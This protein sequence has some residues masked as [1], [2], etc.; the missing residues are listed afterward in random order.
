MAD[1]LKCKHCYEFVSGSNIP[2]TES[3]SIFLFDRYVIHLCKDCFSGLT[4]ID[5]PSDLSRVDSVTNCYQFL[6]FRKG[7]LVAIRHDDGETHT[8]FTIKQNEFNRMFGG[9]HKIIESINLEE[10]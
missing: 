5:N 8:I 4:G 2:A 9:F 1:Q 10:W 3:F 6:E 7:K